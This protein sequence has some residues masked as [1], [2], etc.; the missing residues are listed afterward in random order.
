MI[1]LSCSTA[2]WLQVFSVRSAVRL[3]IIAK[4]ID[5]AFLG[6]LGFF[7]YSMMGFVEAVLLLIIPYHIASIRWVL[8]QMQ[9]SA[10]RR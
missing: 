8:L 2:T 10:I 1:A 5:T 3:A 7:A 4:A 6:T 9:Q